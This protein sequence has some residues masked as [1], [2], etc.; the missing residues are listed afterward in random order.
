M[1]DNGEMKLGS[2]AVTADELEG[3]C[4]DISNSMTEMKDVI[5][6]HAEAIA[7]QRYLFEVFFPKK[8]LEEAAAVYHKRRMAEINAAEMGPDDQSN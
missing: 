4:Q 2:F 5:N 8:Q 1:S 6:I 3:V 7:L